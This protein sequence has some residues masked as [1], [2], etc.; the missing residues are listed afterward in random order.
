M[1]FLHMLFFYSSRKSN[2]SAESTGECSWNERVQDTTRTK[3]NGKRQNNHPRANRYH[4]RY[5]S[6]I[7]C[8]ANTLQRLHS[9][10]GARGPDTLLPRAMSMARALPCREERP[11]PCFARRSLAKS[12]HLISRERRE[13]SGWNLHRTILYRLSCLFIWPRTR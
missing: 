10:L 4:M 7:V 12:G 1:H 2:S 6:K 11:V 8:D 9:L 13:I 5:R 3:A